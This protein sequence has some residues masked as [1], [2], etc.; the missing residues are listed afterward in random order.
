MTAVAQAV[1]E[2]P[3]HARLRRDYLGGG[4]Y[5]SLFFSPARATAMALWAAAQ[6]PDAAAAPS[7][8]AVKLLRGLMAD[9]GADG[10]WRT[11]MENSWLALAMAAYVGR[12]ER[13]PPDFTARVWVGA[14]LAAEHT[15]A[16]YDARSPDAGVGTRVTGLPTRQLFTMT[17]GAAAPPAAGMAAGGGAGRAAGSPLAVPAGPESRTAV[18]VQRAGPTGAGHLYV[19]LRLRTVA[20]ELAAPALA[21][22][23]RVTRTFASVKADGSRAGPLLRRDPLLAGGAGALRVVAGQRLCVTLRVHAEHALNRV[24]IVDRLPA[25]FEHVRSARVAG[26]AEARLQDSDVQM[27]SAP[28]DALARRRDQLQAFYDEM[29]EGA[30]TLSYIVAATT[31]GLFVAPPAS[32]EAMYTPEVFGRCAADTLLVVG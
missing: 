24:A 22:G 11:T 19:T 29:A 32:A 23:I 6:A 15:F 3:A 28:P 2:T 13:T 4:A 30:H 27:F 14:S 9:R 8:L 21:R 1:D 20:A 31:P 18:T 16:G 7:P 12:Y 5:F 17:P 25:G 26:S 10:A